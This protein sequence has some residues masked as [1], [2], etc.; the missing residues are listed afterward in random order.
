MVQCF[1]ED[2]LVWLGDIFVDFCDLTDFGNLL[3]KMAELNWDSGVCNGTGLKMDEACFHVM[4]QSPQP[5]TLFSQ[6]EE[7]YMC[8]FLKWADIPAAGNVSLIVKTVYPVRMYFESDGLQRCHTTYR[9]E[10]HGQYIWNIS[11][12]NCSSIEVLEKPV[13]AYFPLLGAFIFMLLLILLWNVVKWAIDSEW[14]TRLRERAIPFSEI[15]SDL[16][17]PSPSEGPTLVRSEMMPAVRRQKTRVASLDTFRGI[18]IASMIFVNY[19]GGHYYFFK[20]SVWNGLTVADLVF[21]WFLWIMGASLVISLRSQLRS[22]LRR[23]QLFLKV[24]QRSVILIALGLILNSMGGGQRLDLS[25]MRLPGVLQRIGVSYLIVGTIETMLIKPQGSFQIGRLLVVQDVLDSWLQWLVI[26]ILTTVHIS[27]TFLM[28]VPNCPKGYLG[29]GG[30][31]YSLTEGDKYTNCTGGAAGYIDRLVFGEKHIYQHPTFKEVYH[32]SQPYDPEGLLGTLSSVL[33]VYLGV[34][35]GRVMLCYHYTF[36]RV[37]RWTMWAAITGIAAGILCNFSK[38]EGWIPVNKNLWS[39]SYVL[40]MGS[41]S[42]LMQSF[43]YLVIDDRNW[44]SG[45]PFHY[46]GMNSLLL[47]VGHIVTK[48]TFPWNWKPY[49]NNHTELLSMNLWGT[50]LWLIIAYVLFRK[51]VFVAA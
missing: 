8:K 22:T 5:I 17:S 14:M 12:N 24:L 35:A 7:C 13:S 23:R 28:P 42:L 21:P 20:H 27:L 18:A 2:V 19:G 15:E 26:I 40:A 30:L 11:E 31:H 46:A 38:D 3:L 29:P 6:V 44:W 32:T 9:F 49:Y 10:E 41:I 50:A 33:L 43:L 4:S 34:Q 1:I 16:G 36:S 51:N 45:A 48:H 25:S 47:Y 39:L 37:A